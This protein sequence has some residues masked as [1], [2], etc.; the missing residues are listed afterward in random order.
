MKIYQYTTLGAVF[1]GA[2]FLQTSLASAQTSAPAPADATANANGGDPRAQF[3]QRMA[4]QLKASLKATDDE[5]AIIQP[6]L[7][8]VQTL[9]REVSGGGGRMFGGGPGGPGGQG[10]QGGGRRQ[11]RG[12]GTDQGNTNAGGNSNNPGGGGGGWQRGMRGGGNTP[13]AQALRTSLESDS[14]SPSDIKT[15]LQALRDA[16]LKAAAQLEQARADLKKV[17]NMRQEALLV[18]M[19]VLD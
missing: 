5:W 15:Q 6:L 12:A 17:L 2:L 14:A 3:R 11:Q 16:R 13:E 10:G 9:Q 1:A 4:D 18:L 19:G 8:K 7:E